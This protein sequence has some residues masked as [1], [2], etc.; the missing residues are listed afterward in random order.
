MTIRILEVWSSLIV[1]PFLQSDC[2]IYRYFTRK[3]SHSAAN[4]LGLEKI[5]RDLPQFR[6]CQLNMGRRERYCA[7]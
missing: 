6:Q 4:E 3:E 5:A 7:S 2:I 1:R